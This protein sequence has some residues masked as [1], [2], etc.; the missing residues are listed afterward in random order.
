[1]LDIWEAQFWENQWAEYYSTWEMMLLEQI[2]L[3]IGG[4]NSVCLSHIW[5]KLSLTMKP[6]NLKLRISMITTKLQERNS[7]LIQ[8]SKSFHKKLLWSF[9]HMMSLALKHGKQFAKFQEIISKPFIKDL[10]LH[11][12]SLEKVITILSLP[13]C[14]NNLMR[15]GLLKKTIP[16]LRKVWRLIKKVPKK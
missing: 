4:H 10:E 13:K 3:V 5:N 2:M 11:C 6:R 9:K 1:M 7:I 8:L 15:K 14:L 16:Q 12:R